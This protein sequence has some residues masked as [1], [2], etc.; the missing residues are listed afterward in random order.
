MSAISE[1]VVGK[2]VQEKGRQC[3]DHVFLTF[4]SEKVTYEQP[5][6]LSNRFANG[7]KDLGRAF[8]MLCAERY[9]LLYAG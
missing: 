1:N 6:L 3:G 5:D 4:K 7:F 2:L 9:F 8:F